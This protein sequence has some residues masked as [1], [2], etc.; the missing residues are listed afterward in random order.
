[1]PEQRQN[2]DVDVGPQDFA[3]L[4][5]VDALAGFLQ[6]LGYDTSRRSSLTKEAIGINDGD[7]VFRQL[8]LLSEDS[9]GFLRVIFA[10]VRSV[11]AKARNDL[12]RCLGRFSQD[13]LII[14]TSDFK[15]LEFVLIDRVKRHRHGP[16][17]L[18]AYKAVPR[19]YSIARKSPGRLDLR[20]LRGLSWTQRDALDQF[21]KLRN[22]FEAAAYTGEHYQNRALFADHYLDTPRPPG[23]ER[24]KLLFRRFLANNELA[25][26]PLSHR[27]LCRSPCS[28]W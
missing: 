2:V 28:P 7:G 11:T 17:A 9:E 16:A 19:I 27:V 4:A 18:A 21:D 24:F 6:R 13:H 12:V 15:M 1:M 8:E 10:Q 23:Y 25:S 20:V 14:L 26:I 3:A 22:V 5:S